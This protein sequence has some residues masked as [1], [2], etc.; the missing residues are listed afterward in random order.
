MHRPSFPSLPLPPIIP[1]PLFSLANPT[2]HRLVPHPVNNNLHGGN[3]TAPKPH[4][5]A[6]RARFRR[7]S[8]VLLGVSPNPG[9]L[10]GDFLS[11]GGLAELYSGRG[12]F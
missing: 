1:T 4:P 12:G 5:H 10:R 7:N 8:R 11:A 3:Q 9:I 6:Q 2:S